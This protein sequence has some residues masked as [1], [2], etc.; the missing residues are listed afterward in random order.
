MPEDM[1]DRGIDNIVAP[2]V[3]PAKA[4]GSQEVRYSSRDGEAEK[5]HARTSS[6]SSVGGVGDNAVR[7][8]WSSCNSR[9][10][11]SGEKQNHVM[12]SLFSGICGGGGNTERD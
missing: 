8:N 12:T 10:H 4:K 3:A 11:S 7:Y 6:F 9:D 2:P 5:Q 1:L